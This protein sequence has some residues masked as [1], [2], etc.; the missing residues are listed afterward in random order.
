MATVEGGGDG[1]VMLDV[2]GNGCDDMVTE[3]N[4]DISRNGISRIKFNKWEEL[5]EKLMRW[6]AEYGTQSLVRR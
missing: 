5:A 3:V 1:V 2:G 6:T 4:E